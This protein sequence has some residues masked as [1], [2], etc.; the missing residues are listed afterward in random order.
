LFTG[1]TLIT[2]TDDFIRL[3]IEEYEVEV[4]VLPRAKRKQFASMMYTFTKNA[5]RL[6]VSST[7]S[8]TIAGSFLDL[9]NWSADFSAF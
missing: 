1:V 8:N 4:V 6:N 7:K 3:I 9:R 5:I 2:D